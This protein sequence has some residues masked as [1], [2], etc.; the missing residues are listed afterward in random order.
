[1]PIATGVIDGREAMVQILTLPI[2]LAFGGLAI[3]IIFRLIA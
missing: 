3:G 2:V 1:V